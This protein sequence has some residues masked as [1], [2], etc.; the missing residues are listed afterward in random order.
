M[1]GL[2]SLKFMKREFIELIKNN[3]S[4]T[5][6]MLFVV[7]TFATWSIWI[8][9]GAI[10]KD[11]LLYLKQAFF[12]SEGKTS[13]ALHL[14]PYPFYSYLIGSIYKL[15]GV[16]LLWIAHGINLILFGIAT[17]FYL[18]TLRLI[19]NSSTIVFY[20]GITLLSFMPIMDDYVGMLVRDH[21]MWAGCMA[22]TYFFLK[23]RETNNNKY[24]LL[25]NFSLLFAT[26]FRPEAL[27]YLFVMPC[28]EFFL[29]K[30]KSFKS[31]L[32]SF[33][34]ILAIFT[35]S[36]IFLAYSQ[37]VMIQNVIPTVLEKI[38]NLTV[39]FDRSE[40]IATDNFWLSF[41]LNDYSKLILFGGLTFVF[42]FK[43]FVSLGVIH[44]S[45]LLFG[46]K[47]K[48]SFITKYKLVIFTLAATS[49]FLVF[50]NLIN[51]Y[52]VSGRYFVMH[53][54]WLLLIIAASLKYIDVSVNIK[55]INFI[56]KI[57][58]F[59]ITVLILNSV[60]DSKNI[61]VERLAGNYLGSQYK[62][63]VIKSIDADRVLFYAGMPFDSIILSSTIN[64]DEADI[65]VIQSNSD[66]DISSFNG[67][68]E[69]ER[70]V[71][72]NKH[73]SI[74]KRKT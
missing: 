63:Y 31:L 59:F 23:A 5:G 2:E 41:L 54:W 64:V 32:V 15:T 6:I 73:V 9:A 50:L 45:I 51:V 11:G 52:V 1:P 22:A 17:F 25:W 61:D 44:L 35:I 3:L 8:Q 70:F 16:S 48:F 30:N 36:L 18:K 65:L 71:K 66:L 19:D 7:M 43:W 29:L 37:I 28:I 68:D 26:F 13:E 38:L 10:N 69:L 56:R 21:G 53:W 47:N 12:F 42:I 60:I 20:G 46:L 39:F 24:Y 74:M 55:W 49:L 27:I 58:Y 40:A 62:S 14:F 67:F 33:R 72:K 57:L 34:F 4:K